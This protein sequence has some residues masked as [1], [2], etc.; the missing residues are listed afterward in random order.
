MQGHAARGLKIRD[1]LTMNNDIQE[2]NKT[3]RSVRLALIK[4][5]SVDL[6]DKETVC[7][8]LATD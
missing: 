1:D 7:C 6:L 4:I 2:L 5:K 3:A 8:A